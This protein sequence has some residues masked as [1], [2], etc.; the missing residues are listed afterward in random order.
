[1]LPNSWDYPVTLCDPCMADVYS[2]VL[3]KNYGVD[4]N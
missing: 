1:M 4:V 2:T 3:H